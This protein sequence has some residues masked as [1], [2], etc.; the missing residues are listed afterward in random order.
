[1]LSMES[2]RDKKFAGRGERI[3]K[4]SEGVFINFSVWHVY[5]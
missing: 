5:L 3:K 1:M 2:E 4:F